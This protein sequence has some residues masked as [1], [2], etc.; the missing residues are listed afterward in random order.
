MQGFK[1]GISFSVFLFLAALVW[2]PASYAQELP[3]THENVWKTG[4]ITVKQDAR[5]TDILKRQISQNKR[6][7]GVDGYRIQILF[8]SGPGARNQAIRAKADFLS[9]YPG[10][11]VYILYQSPFYKVRIGDFVLK[12]DA[13][14]VYHQIKNKYP[15]AFIVNDI[16]RFPD[17]N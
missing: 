13:L 15:T 10:Y 11:P 5:V 17:L 14:K 12:R 3:D 4:T 1:S 7:N 8:N 16:V 9:A 2:W 6:K